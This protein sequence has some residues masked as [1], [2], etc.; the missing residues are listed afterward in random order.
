M[1]VN[2][3]LLQFNFK[4]NYLNQVTSLVAQWLRPHTFTAGG[5]GLFPSQ[6]TKILCVS[7][8]INK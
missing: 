2:N 7:G 4:Q 6:G 8:P 5:T 3:K 1:I